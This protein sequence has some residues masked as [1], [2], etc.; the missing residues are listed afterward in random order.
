M[1][2]SRKSFLGQITQILVVG[3][4]VRSY[5]TYEGCYPN[6]YE[7]RTNFGQELMRWVHKAAIRRGER[8]LARDPSQRNRILSRLMPAQLMN[9]TKRGP[10]PQPKQQ[11]KK[12]HTAF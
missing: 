2:S 3:Y 5:T 9:C 6:R 11:E 8:M 10:A 7:R 1:S 12:G 4:T